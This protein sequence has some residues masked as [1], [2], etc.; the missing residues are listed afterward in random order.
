[1]TKE[2]VFSENLLG[3]G[4]AHK[5]TNDFLGDYLAVATSNVILNTHRSDFEAIGCHA[6]LTEEEMTVPFIAIEVK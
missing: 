5:K 3:Y 6:G 2:E 4:T 1:M